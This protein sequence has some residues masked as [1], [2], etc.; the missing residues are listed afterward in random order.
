MIID[1]VAKNNMIQN[2]ERVIMIIPLCHMPQLHFN[3][4]TPVNLEPY[5]LP[6]LEPMELPEIELI[7][8]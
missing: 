5:G 2:M 6:K 8:L 4:E 3:L 1:N 7:M